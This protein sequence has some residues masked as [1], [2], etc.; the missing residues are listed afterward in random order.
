MPSPSVTPVLGAFPAD[1]SCVRW[2]LAL[3]EDDR[4]SAATDC[5]Q[6]AHQGAQP[7]RRT[8]HNPLATPHVA[9]AYGIE[10][11]ELDISRPKA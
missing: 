4:V 5:W 10:T 8:A 6:P 7:A 3:R 9:L 2:R 11:L 1:S